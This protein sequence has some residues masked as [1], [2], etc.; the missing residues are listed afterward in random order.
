VLAKL[1][2]DAV[3]LLHF[4]FVLFAIFGGVLVLYRKWVIWLHLPAVV[5]S[6]LVNL[7]GWVCPLTP[8]ENYFYV[9]AGQAGYAGGF[10][11]H[12]LAPLVYPDAMPRQLQLTA[13]VSIVVWNI[14]VYAFV[15]WRR[16]RR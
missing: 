4:A 2:A 10:V 13:A 8:L 16:Q 3:L 7:A 5:W 11:E 15:V 14:L 1:L 9:A 6:A 12:Y